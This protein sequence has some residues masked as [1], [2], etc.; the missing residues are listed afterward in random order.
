MKFFTV[1]LIVLLIATTSHATGI[2]TYA[3]IVAANL[4]GDDIVLAPNVIIPC[5]EQIMLTTDYQEVYTLGYP[6]GS[7]RATLKL[8]GGAG[9]ILRTS[10]SVVGLKIHHL[11]LDG[12][13]R[14]LGHNPVPFNELNPW[15]NPP[16]IT[17]KDTIGVEVYHVKTFDPRC[18]SSLVI[19]GVDTTRSKI[20]HNQI[21]NAGSILLRQWKDGISIDQPNVDV[22]NNDIIDVTDGGIVIFG[23]AT[24]SHIYDNTITSNEKNMLLGIGLTDYKPNGDYSG[25]IVEHNIIQAIGTGWMF[26]G[27]AAGNR[28][29][30][31]DEYEDNNHDATIVYNTIAGDNIGFPIIVSGVDNY[32]VDNNI[33][34]LNTIY[35]DNT[36]VVGNIDNTD[37][38]SLNADSLH[39]F[40]AAS[41]FVYSNYHYLLNRNPDR[42]GAVYFLTNKMRQQPCDQSS[43][44]NITLFMISS[45]EGTGI[46]AATPTDEIVDNLY[47]IIF[48]SK[49]DAVGRAWWIDRIDSSSDRVAE[50][51]FLVACL[52]HSP[53]FIGN[54]LPSLCQ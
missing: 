14:V 29:W 7:D 49:P 24:G 28:L 38:T 40:P 16:L 25:V 43:L 8:I 35:V 3:G 13:S 12:N 37:Q 33:V 54:I 46:V 19:Q 41:I 9:A 6:A 48:Q 52:Y 2:T 11:I 34:P 31:G 51:K 17:L 18:W 27:I 10:G 36:H 26:T 5:P 20:H 21:T 32:C 22:Y 44:M 45:Q 47:M 23:G 39:N 4:A 15:D 53:F 30:F 50:I 1:L 42:G